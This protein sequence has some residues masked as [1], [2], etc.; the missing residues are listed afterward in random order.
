MGVFSVSLNSC[1]L[2]AAGGGF[3]TTVF[4]ANTAASG[5]LGGQAAGQVIPEPDVQLEVLFQRQKNFHDHF[6]C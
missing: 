4:F 1:I 6:M 5:Q 3:L 2:T